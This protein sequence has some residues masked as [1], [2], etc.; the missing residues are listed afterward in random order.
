[1]N[2]IMLLSTDVKLSV[3]VK[4]KFPKRCVVCSGKSPDKRMS[5]GDFMVGWFSLFTD[6]PEGWGSVSVPVHTECKR[7]F[8]LRRWMTRISYIS[9]A[10]LIYWYFGAPLEAMFPAEIRQ[11]GRKIILFPI[12]FLMGLIEAFY[13]QRFD[14]SVSKYYI[15]FQFADPLYAAAFAK[16]NGERNRL[17]E[18]KSEHPLLDV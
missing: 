8:R 18:I 10:C 14:I 3:N 4:P 5:V 17:E 16:A 9:T 6:L 1:M 2:Q 12:L 7:P 11:L 13:P 15:T